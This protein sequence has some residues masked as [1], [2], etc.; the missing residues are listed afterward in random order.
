MVKIDRRWNEKIFRRIDRKL[1]CNFSVSRNFK[2]PRDR[3][4]VAL[5]TSMLFPTNF[6]TTAALF[7]NFLKT[8]LSRV[9]KNCQKSVWPVDYPNVEVSAKFPPWEWKPWTE[10]DMYARTMLI[11]SRASP[12]LTEVTRGGWNR[13]LVETKAAKGWTTYE[14]WRGITNLGRGGVFSVGVSFTGGAEEPL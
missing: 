4:I 12:P 10:K 3:Y 6:A 14:N 1:R 13:H 8:V 9:N 11:I 7:K 5:A 2:T